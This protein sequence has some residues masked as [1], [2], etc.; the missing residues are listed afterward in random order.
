[1]KRILSIIISVFVMLF[2]IG[3]VNNGET[4][5]NNENPLMAGVSGNVRNIT[6]MRGANL[7]IY[8]SY[9]HIILEQDKNYWGFVTPEEWHSNSYPRRNATSED[10]FFSVENNRFY[11]N[12]DGMPLDWV[13]VGSY[14]FLGLYNIW[15]DEIPSHAR[16]IRRI[17]IIQV[18]RVYQSVSFNQA[19]Q[20]LTLTLRNFVNG[21]ITASTV[22]ININENAQITRE[23]DSNGNL[24][25][26]HAGVSIEF[27][28]S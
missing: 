6:V 7:N 18:I 13:Y 28:V 26:L 8:R 12:S 27:F 14:V 15:Y 23:Y 20:I 3:C 10:P 5:N 9:Y 2:L 22:N 24:T 17:P 11:L 4:S 19:T 1:M 25:Y 21:E 16:M